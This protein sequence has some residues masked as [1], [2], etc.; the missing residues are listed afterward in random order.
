MTFDTKDTIFALASARGV[1]G[2][3]VVRVSGSNA[4]QTLKKISKIN[5]LIPRVANV[6]TLYS[7]KDQQIIDQ[8]IVI[9]FS[10]P[11][12]FTGEDVVELHCH[13]GLAVL[14]AIFSTLLALGLRPAEPGEFSR[15]AFCNGRMD[16]VQAEGLADLIDARTEGQRQQALQQM[17]GKLSLHIDQ[18]RQLL[19]AILARIE[20]EIDFSDE[21]DVTGEVTE[22]V[23]PK[24]IELTERLEQQLTS[25]KQGQQVRDGYLI[26]LIGR[27]NAGKSTLL[28]ALVGD[29]R[30]IVSAQPGTTRDV[31]E[32]QL[33]IGGFFVTIADTAGLRETSEVIEQEG[34]RRTHNTAKTAD[35]RL[36]LLECGKQNSP[37]NQQ[38]L[39]QAKP[40]DLVL[41]TK[42]DLAP[43]QTKQDGQ[44]AISAKTGVGMDQL[45]LHLE[46]LVCQTLGNTETPALTRDRHVRMVGGALIALKA[47]KTEVSKQQKCLPELVAE[48]LRHAS[49]LLGGLL[50]QVHSE[51]VL[52]EIFS[53]FC[54][55]K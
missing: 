42:L 5:N 24:L 19:L 12:S 32:A 45:L 34:I 9:Y 46:K 7:P 8:A 3:S 22:Q 30:A 1:A 52:D 40:R 16:L 31:V 20:A 36:F 28:N 11:N 6:T 17:G 23:L 48:E 49:Q 33:Q 15:R 51:Q 43:D 55:G 25:A 10:A 44:L 54:I 37:E 38:L 53:G 41:H 18:W 14:E 27:V 4:V 29:E 50:G 26:A 2:V 39:A 35:L 13:G 47:A 21:E